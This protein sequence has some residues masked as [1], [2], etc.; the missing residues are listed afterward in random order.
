MVPSL[1]ALGSV[2][3]GQEKNAERGVERA[4][5]R[6][7]LPTSRLAS[8]VAILLDRSDLVSDSAP[9]ATR[10]RA[11]WSRGAISEA[12]G[13]L[14][15]AGEQNFPLCEPPAQRSAASPA[16]LQPSYASSHE[17]THASIA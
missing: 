10:A 11:A 7:G 12:L 16:R 13:I 4:V 8:E 15:D 6:A 17:S 1:G 3:A 14:E 2:M 9:A 5:S